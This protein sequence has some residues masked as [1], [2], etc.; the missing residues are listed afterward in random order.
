MGKRTYTIIGL[1]GMVVVF[2]LGST[3]AQTHSATQAESSKAAVVILQGEI[4]D[5]SHD[6]LIRHFNDARA[7]GAKT[8]ILQLDTYG[9]SVVSGLEISQFIKQ[10]TDV[11]VIAYIPRKAISAGAMIAMA[12]DEI[13]MKPEAI[14]GDCAP[15]VFNFNGD[16]ESLPDAERGKQEAPIRADFEDSARRNGYSPLL[17]DSM[18][19]VGTVVHDIESPDGT[20]RFVNQADFD[21]FTATGWKT[22]DGVPDPL[23]GPKQLL[24]LHT[25]LAQKIGLCKQVEDSADSLASSRSYNILATFGPSTGEDIIEF[26]GTAFARGLLITLFILSLKIAISAPGHGVAE[27]IAL[28]T[29]CLLVGVPLLTGFA[30]WWEIAIIFVGLGL[31]AFEVFVF[32]GHFVSAIFGGLMI[33]G[34]L[35]MTFVPK[36]PGGMPG[37]LPGLPMTYTAMQR[38]LVVVLAGMLCSLMLWMWLQRYLP[39]VPYFR[40]LVLNTS[41]GSTKTGESIASTAWPIIGTFGVAMTD[42]RPGGKGAFLDEAAGGDRITQVV[43]ENGFAPA[44]AKLQVREVE[45]NHVLVRAIG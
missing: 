41:V 34:G 27:S 3:F 15:I 36:E 28:I 19:S 45:G 31:V 6:S 21:K 40:K 42:L 14:I 7:A 11:H 33:I 5:Y 37:L 35:V 29:L 16:L 24:T 20:R 30:Q 26:L 4:D 17:A 32:P 22:V 23:N 38:G 12:C 2:A 44:G 1:L 8:I 39:S 18:V 10:Q 9:G 13:V 43:S 25:D